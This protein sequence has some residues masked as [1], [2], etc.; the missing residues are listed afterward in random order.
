MRTSL[1]ACI[2]ACAFAGCGGGDDDKVARVPTVSS[3]TKRAT[4][5]P[6]QIAAGERAVA[7]SGC[8]ACHQIGARGQSGPG[9]NLTGIGDRMAR[10]AIRRSL[11][12]APAPMPS[13]RQLPRDRLEALVTYLSS[14]RAEPSCRDDDHDCG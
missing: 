9:S 3:P 5:A 13:Y 7:D 4:A 11:L 2:V 1:L 8:L 10:S 6:E 14:L 12:N